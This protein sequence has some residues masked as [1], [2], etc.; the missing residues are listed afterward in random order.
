MIR[1]KCFVTLLVTALALMLCGTE[2]ALAADGSDKLV[3]VRMGLAARSTT[4]MP[5]FVAKERGFF[6]EEGL[7][8]ELIV[9]QAIQTIQATMGNST[10]FASATGS[11]V[12]SAV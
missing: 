12:S 4:S 8:V 9:M 3:R 6:R 2:H 5:F 11:A 7:E 10:Q 1:T